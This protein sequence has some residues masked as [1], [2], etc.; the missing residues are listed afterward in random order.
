MI[1]EKVNKIFILALKVIFVLITLLFVYLMYES[2]LIFTKYDFKILDFSFLISSIFYSILYFYFLILI[3]ILIGLFRKYNKLVKYVIFLIPIIPILFISLRI[4]QT[5]GVVEEDIA[6]LM[7][8]YILL[9]FFTM[10]FIVKRLLNVI[11]NFI[12]GKKIGDMGD[13]LFVISVFSKYPYIKGN[14]TSLIKD[15]ITNFLNYEIAN[16]DFIHINGKK[17]E[18]WNY[19]REGKHTVFHTEN[20]LLTE[21]KAK[22][23][24]FKNPA[25]IENNFEDKEYM[26]VYIYQ[27]Y[28]NGDE[29]SG[30]PST[31]DD[32]YLALKKILPEDTLIYY[33]KDADITPSEIWDLLHNLFNKY[34]ILKYGTLIDKAE[35]IIK[36]IAKKLKHPYK[37]AIK[38]CLI[39]LV[40]LVILYY[41]YYYYLYDFLHKLDTPTLIIII[42]GILSIPI[43]IYS[44]IQIYDRIYKNKK[45]N[46]LQ[47]LIFME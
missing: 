43:S 45:P 37:M 36:D 6:L 2:S 13:D 4:H 3:T 23:T 14:V 8:F 38:Y 47:A 39:L 24:D 18:V 41:I 1:S 11:S 7:I 22:S 25:I 20:I 35:I 28:D 31:F 15:V 5:R 30:L 42:T 12:I 9:F 19:S 26:C 40:I 44:C 21:L 29:I 10:L 46:N 27:L 17:Y 16:V 34:L 33:N 32:L